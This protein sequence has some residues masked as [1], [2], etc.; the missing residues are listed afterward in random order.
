MMLSAAL[1]VASHAEVWQELLAA[2]SSERLQKIA[3]ERGK[4]YRSAAPFPHVVI[5]DLFPA[6]VVEAVAAEHAE[7]NA[8]C[9]SHSTQ[10]FQHD[11]HSPGKS[12]VDKEEALGPATRLVFA[13]LKSSTFLTFL[14]RLTGIS[15][16]IPDPHFRGSG[17]HL[18]ANHGRLDIHSDFNRY[19]RFK[20]DRRVNVFLFLNRDWHETYGGHLELWA[21]NMSSCA[22]RIAP[23]MGRFVAFSSTDFSFHGHPEPME[24]PPGR[25]RRSLALYYYT[26]GRP[27]DECLEGRCQSMHS[28]LWQ[29]PSACASCMACRAPQAAAAVLSA[30][31]SSE[32]PHSHHRR[33]KAEISIENRVDTG[34]ARRSRSSRESTR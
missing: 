3:R 11:L 22:H 4:G 5:D 1:V 15:A 16:L 6:S 24:L 10:C 8:P 28:T 19:V 33:Q 9:H 32:Q 25:M 27:R 20:L 7:E 26:N 2:A 12:A 30:P 31:P 18:T 14:E 23:I 29:V 21:R 13:V 17:L 34:T